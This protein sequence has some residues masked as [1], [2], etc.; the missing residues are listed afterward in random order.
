MKFARLIVYI[1]PGRSLRHVVRFDSSRLNFAPGL[2]FPRGFLRTIVYKQCLFIY[3]F[4]IEKYQIELISNGFL[5]S[6]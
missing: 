1:H 5:L 4:R 3:L 2:A 6:R